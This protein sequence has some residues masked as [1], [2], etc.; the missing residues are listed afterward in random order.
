MAISP[1]DITSVLTTPHAHKSAHDLRGR[2]VT[3][4][5]D[6]SGG[7]LGGF[8]MTGSVFEGPVRCDDVTFTGL[9]WLRN[10][11]FLGG[12]SARATQFAQD[13][14]FDDSDITGTFDMSGASFMG[15]LVLDGARIEGSAFLDELEVLGS[16]SMARAGFDGPVSLEGTEAL[17][18]LWADKTAFRNRLTATGMEIHGRNWIR[19]ARFV[20]GLP[21]PLQALSYGYVWS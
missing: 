4:A 10:C 16:L 7:I 3:G 9:T 20:T 5:L 12:V 19:G 21:L 14:R 8:D 6:L 11:R 13:A 2:R 1:A 18:G 15:Q 17:G